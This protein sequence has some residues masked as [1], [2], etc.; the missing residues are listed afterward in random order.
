MKYLRYFHARVL[1]F[2]V[3]MVTSAKCLALNLTEAY[4]AALLNDPNMQIARAEYQAGLE[5]INIAR[6][7]LLPQIEAS[8]SR[9]RRET[10]SQGLF[11]I[12][13]DGDQDPRTPEIR[14][15]RPVVKTTN[16]IIDT[17][18]VSL[19]QMIYDAAEWH[20][21][22]QGKFQTEQAKY[23]FEVQ[24]QELV[25]RVISAYID[26]LRTQDDLEISRLLVDADS[27]QLVHS[28]KRARVGANAQSDVFQVQASYD[29]SVANQ[30]RNEDL[31]GESKDTLSLIIGG[32]DS[33][34]W[35]LRKNFQPKALDPPEADEWL[36][37]ALRSSPAIKVAQANR[38]AAEA[39]YKSAR[40]HYLPKVYTQISYNESDNDTHEIDN[41]IPLDY[42]STSDDASISVNLSI[43][44]YSGGRD[45]AVSRQTKFQYTAAE[46]SYDAAIEDTK[47]QVFTLHRAVLSNISRMTA[48]EKAVRSTEKALR[49]MQIR[50]DT[51]IS[52]INDLLAAQRSYYNA[53][54]DLNNTRYDYILKTAELKKVTG[55]L[56][57]LAVHQLNSELIQP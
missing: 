18:G 20:R 30:L 26:I 57:P 44:L 14:A 8:G 46:R 37:V 35:S 45:S 13:V 2:C 32:L 34:L 5:A 11:P 16:E 19:R 6:G 49:A 42:D 51:G 28:S 53:V 31:L 9:Q 27:N 7:G 56:N 50:Y 23:E 40:S 21:Y 54:R 1:V 33:E 55:L 15:L 10:D 52:E 17:W 38:D 47:R 48:N 43:P 24:L 25:L 29:V 4:E 22:K 3:L 36:T 41:R 12:T 39:A